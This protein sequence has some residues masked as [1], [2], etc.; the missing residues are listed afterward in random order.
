MPSHVI[1]LFVFA[2]ITIAC[3]ISAHRKIVV[4]DFSKP[5]WSEFAVLIVAV[6]VHV[7]IA[8]NSDVGARLATA[9]TLNFITVVFGI[10]GPILMLLLPGDGRVLS[11]FSVCVSVP[12]TAV[13]AL[14]HIINVIESK[15]C[16][17]YFVIP[18]IIGVVVLCC[19]NKICEVKSPGE[20]C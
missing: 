13:G 4:K 11:L 2:I 20:V 1:S 7:F 9:D 5:I 3:L 14:L 17:Y 6:I 8:M 18:G 19:L 16:L 10:A 12:F 15:L